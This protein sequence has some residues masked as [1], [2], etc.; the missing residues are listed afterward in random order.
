VEN[1]I[2]KLKNIYFLNLLFGQSQLF[3]NRSLSTIQNDGHLISRLIHILL[4]VIL[5]ISLSA[6]KSDSNPESPPEPLQ[7][8]DIQEVIDATDIDTLIHFV[9]QLSGEVPVTIN[10]RTIIVE[11]RYYDK[12]GND[13]ACDFIEMKFKSYGL[14]V[15]QQFFSSSGRNIFAIQLGAKYPSQRYIVCAH[16]DCYPD[17]EIAPGADDN[18]SGTAAVL[19]AARIL[20]QYSSDYTIVYALWDEEEQGLLGSFYYAYQADNIGENIMGVINMD[21]IGWDSDDDGKFWINTHE[22]AAQSLHL[23]DR[24]VAIHDEFGLGLSPQVLNPGSGSDNISFWYGGYSAIGVEEMYGMDWNEYYHTT[25][26]RLDK[27]NLT[28]F[29]QI[30]RLVIATLASLAEISN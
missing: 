20:C 26:D 12:P 1:K 16:Y 21:M 29:H 3:L 10:G 6:C 17:S 5:L 27:F 13:L 2:T 4:I 30:S 28:Y 8:I 11:S 22:E 7:D 14:E 19:E 24:M 23:S 9:E 18:A 15:F 25:D